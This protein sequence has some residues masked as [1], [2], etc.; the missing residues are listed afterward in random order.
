[1]QFVKSYYI[2]PYIFCC[3]LLV[4]IY[5]YITSSAPDRS[6]GPKRITCSYGTSS[7]FRCAFQTPPA[8]FTC[9]RGAVSSLPREGRPPPRLPIALFYAQLYRLVALALL[10]L[11][12]IPHTDPPRTI[13]R[14]QLLR[15]WWPW[16][17][18]QTGSHR[19]APARVRGCLTPIIIEVSARKVNRPL[20][21]GHRI[22][23]T[24]P[25]TVP[26]VPLKRLLYSRPS[27]RISATGDQM[28]PP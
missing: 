12:P 5:P 24:R 2:Q 14:G 3:H 25:I 26:V 11:L 15:P 9:C 6:H 27:G 4:Y 21:Q 22:E 1:M 7:T 18:R 23:E 28:R 17:Q 10:S 20:R 8:G 13:T 19:S 16:Q